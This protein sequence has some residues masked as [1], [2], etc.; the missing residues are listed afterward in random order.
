[1]TGRGEF[2]LKIADLP[3][4]HADRAIALLWYYRQSQEFEERSAKDLAADMQEEGF[5]RPNITR[6]KEDLQRSRFT[7]KGRQ[8]GTFQIDL[9]RA[10]ALEQK[11]GEFLG[12]KRV[13]VTAKV[14]PSEW[15]VGTR[16]YLEQLVYQINGCYESGFYD[17]CAA[18]CRRLMES[19]I[20]EVYVH[21]QRHHQIQSNGVFLPLERLIGFITVDTRVALGRNTPKTMIETKQLGDTAAH[22][23]VY[24]TPQIDIDDH[25]AKYRRMIQEL[26]EKANIL[27]T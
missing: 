16:R 14:I 9:R 17:A 15:V 18:L 10:S 12:T 3:L 7:V 22:D 8:E 19:L 4:S 25:K 26:L 2:S 5:P 13:P 1:M 11:Y 23:R 27:K 24:I 20:I 21:E 6:F